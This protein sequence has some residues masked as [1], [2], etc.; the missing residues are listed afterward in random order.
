VQYDESFLSNEITEEENN[1]TKIY[2]WSP[3]L[4]PKC[5]Y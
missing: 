2:Q 4:I 5:N 3:Q 1:P